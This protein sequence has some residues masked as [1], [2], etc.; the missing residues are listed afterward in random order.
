MG[1]KK[2]ISGWKYHNLERQAVFTLKNRTSSI[3]G[4]QEAFVE[5]T[6]FWHFITTATLYLLNIHLTCIFPLGSRLLFVPA[7]CL[8][9]NNDDSINFYCEYM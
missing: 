2:N 5:V 6:A 9:L 8:I 4:E 7:Q 3:S 1:K